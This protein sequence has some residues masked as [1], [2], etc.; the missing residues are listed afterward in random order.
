V[1]ALTTLIALLLATALTRFV[2]R[3]AMRA[4]REGWRHRRA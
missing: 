1:V 2:E 3:P 4:L